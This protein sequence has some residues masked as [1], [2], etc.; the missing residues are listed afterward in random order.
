MAGYN[1]K[2]QGGSCKS[3]RNSAN[4]GQIF[5]RTKKEEVAAKVPSIFVIY[6]FVNL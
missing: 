6:Y 3:P 1:H 5:H 2:T 4:N